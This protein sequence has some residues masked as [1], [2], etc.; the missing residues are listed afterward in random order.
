MLNALPLERQKKCY[1]AW[2]FM[3]HGNRTRGGANYDHETKKWQ[4]H[5][6]RSSACFDHTWTK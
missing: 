1:N 2:I 3:V 4:L 6:L 5:T